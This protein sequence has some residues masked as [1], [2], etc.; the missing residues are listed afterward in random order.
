MHKFDFIQALHLTSAKL[1]VAINRLLKHCRFTHPWLIVMALFLALGITIESTY[2]MVVKPHPIE[3][4]S[5]LAL[6]VTSMVVFTKHP[7]VGGQ[8]LIV[9]TYLANF[10]TFSVPAMTL[11]DGF[12][13]VGAL[14]YISVKAGVFSSAHFIAGTVVT[15]VFIDDRFMYRGGLSAFAIATLLTMLGGNALRWKQQRDKAVSES[16]ATK[17]NVRTA[18]LLHDH[19]CNDLTTIILICDSLSNQVDGCVSISSDLRKTDTPGVASIRKAAIEALS[20]ARQAIAITQGEPCDGLVALP[21]KDN[22][23]SPQNTL[24]M[25]VNQQ[26]HSLELIGFQGSI[27][28]PEHCLD[29]LSDSVAAL[30]IELTRELF[31]NIAKHANPTA[32]YSLVFSQ[33]N[34][35]V[36]VTLCD[37][38]AP[39]VSSSG[40]G[41]SRYQVAILACGGTWH[42]DKTDDMWT[43][44][45][46][47][48]T[49]HTHIQYPH[50]HHNQGGHS[51]LR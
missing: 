6:Q 39:D 4:I 19:T 43:L 48:P 40:T 5:F 30:L 15:A 21:I 25:L 3:Q 11:L 32:G 47:F 26:Q 34:D 41:L 24:Q 29:N 10:T 51:L 7:H 18:A 28:I 42:I 44:T 46:S 12:V 38:P 36:E 23:H 37:K 20:Y 49:T 9:L 35:K 22:E 31:G 2:W 45:A 27:I 8:M 16:Q 50:H 14:S 1:R 13:A 33:E 17:R